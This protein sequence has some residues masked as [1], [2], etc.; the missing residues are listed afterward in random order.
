MDV[1]ATHAYASLLTR[2]G[3]D[4]DE[5]LDPD[6]YLLPSS[7]M[8]AAMSPVVNVDMHGGRCADI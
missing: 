8:E 6:N 3:V 7:V 5:A 2:A 4:A 1:R